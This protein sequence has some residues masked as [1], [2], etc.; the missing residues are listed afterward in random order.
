MT[1]L[2]VDLLDPDSEPSDEQLVFLM[3]EVAS[4]VVARADRA[5]LVF[6]QD[7]ASKLA[8]AA[9]RVMARSATALSM[10]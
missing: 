9:E 6:A 5:N 10:S 4:E 8:S 1:E 2:P 3:E 7:L